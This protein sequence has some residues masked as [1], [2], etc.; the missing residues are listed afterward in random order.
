MNFTFRITNLI[1]QNS[2]IVIYWSN[3]VDYKQNTADKVTTVTIY[4]TTQTTG[5]DSA[6]I[7]SSR[8]TIT[9]NGL[10]DSTQLDV[11]SSDIVIAIDQLSNL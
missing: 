2:K 6:S 9:I 1:L 8:R 4:R 11:Q 5:T 10:F 3:S 7:S